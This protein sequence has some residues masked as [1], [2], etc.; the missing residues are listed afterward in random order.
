[1]NKTATAI[2]SAISAAATVLV[3]QNMMTNKGKVKR[4]LKSAVDKGTD[5]VSQAIDKGSDYIS[6]ATS[7]ASDYLKQTN[8]FK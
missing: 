3:A 7:N 4:T 6:S 2:I 8:V 5:Y 1:M